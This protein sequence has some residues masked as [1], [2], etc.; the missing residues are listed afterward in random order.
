VQ[1][2]NVAQ[3]QLRNIEKSINAANNTS[4]FFGQSSKEQ[5]KNY[6]QW[7]DTAIYEKH[8]QQEKMLKESH[9]KNQHLY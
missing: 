1:K 5:R 6:S 7:A 4:L 3:S 9:K 2:S 8:K